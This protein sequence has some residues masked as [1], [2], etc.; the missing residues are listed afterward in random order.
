MTVSGTTGL[1]TKVSNQKTGIS[2]DFQQSVCIF[3]KNKLF[4]V[5]NAVK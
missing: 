5:Y 1:I 4:A 2:L 3:K